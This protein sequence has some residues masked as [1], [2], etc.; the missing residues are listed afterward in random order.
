MEIRMWEEAKYIDGGVRVGETETHWID[1]LTMIVNFRVVTAPKDGPDAYDRYWCYAG[2]GPVDFVNALVAVMLWAKDGADEPAGWIKNG[3]T[4]ETRIP[5]TD[6]GRSAMTED[7]QV[8]TKEE[9][10]V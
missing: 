8:T 6:G 10:R 1:I 4:G 7:S 5:V 9:H 2:R 3:Q